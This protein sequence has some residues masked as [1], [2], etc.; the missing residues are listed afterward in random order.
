LITC[1]TRHEA[2]GDRR[3]LKKRASRKVQARVT[4][5]EPPHGHVHAGVEGDGLERADDSELGG[6][7]VVAPA[8]ARASFSTRSIVGLEATNVPCPDD[9]TGVCERANSTMLAKR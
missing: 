5:S 1:R 6:R 7:R 2:H 8:R 4:Y 9:P 3:V